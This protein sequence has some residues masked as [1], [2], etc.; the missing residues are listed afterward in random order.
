L[1]NKF[2]NLALVSRSINSQFSNK[3]Y[4]EKRERFLASNLAKLDS[5][6]LSLIY[7][8]PIWND[9]ICQNHENEMKDLIKQYFNLN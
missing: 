9:E 4:K 3:S 7:D 6:K 2:G 5:L 1:L 8:N